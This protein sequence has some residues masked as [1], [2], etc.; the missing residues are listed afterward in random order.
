MIFFIYTKYLPSIIIHLI[1]LFDYLFYNSKNFILNKLVK[2]FE[3]K[4]LFTFE[5]Y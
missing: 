1:T 4:I 2:L 5:N 3:K